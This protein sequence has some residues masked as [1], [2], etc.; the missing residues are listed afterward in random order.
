MSRWI[1]LVTLHRALVERSPS[2]AAE[3]LEWARQA[4]EQHGGRLEV[5]D[6]GEARTLGYAVESP[7]M[8]GPGYDEQ[9]R[10]E[11]A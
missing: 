8:P 10:R 2:A 6:G 7:E 5:V 1:A 4:A 3:I 11:S 9:T